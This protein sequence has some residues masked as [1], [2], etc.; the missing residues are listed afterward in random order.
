MFII[1]HNFSKILMPF[2]GKFAI[3]YTMTGAHVKSQGF[4]TIDL[5]NIT[6]KVRDM[7]GDYYNEFG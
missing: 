6:D 3:L 1:R 2:G 7:Y 5:G 4:F